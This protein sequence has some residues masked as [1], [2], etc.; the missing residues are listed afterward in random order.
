[1]IR[2]LK[3]MVQVESRSLFCNARN[4]SATPASPACVATSICSTYFAFG[5][6]SLILVPPFTDFS[7]EPDIANEVTAPEA[8]WVIG[9]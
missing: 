7:K 2:A 5:A 4:I 3:T 9:G 8:Y 6:A 1:M